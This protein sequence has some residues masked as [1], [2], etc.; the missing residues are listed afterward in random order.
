MPLPF[1]DVARPQ[2]RVLRQLAAALIYEGRID[3]RTSGDAFGTVFTWTATGRR[4]RAFGRIGPFGRPRLAPG[5]VEMNAGGRW[6]TGTVAQLIHDVAAASPAAP[7]FEAELAATI[8]AG[9][10]VGTRLRERR[11]ASFAALESALDEGHPYHPSF[12]SRTGFTAAD[13]ARYGQGAPPFRLIW[14]MVR[15][16]R[17][18]LSGAATRPDFWAEAI[19]PAG[20]E[21]AAVVAERAGWSLEA[22][23]LLPVHPF[24]LA[25]LDGTFAAAISAGAVIPLGATGD[26]YLAGQSLRTLFNV[27]RPAA[28]C[29]K[30]PIDVTNTSIRRVL[31][32]HSVVAAPHLSAWLAG[33]I[34]GDP[35]FRRMPVTL[36][37]EYAG[38]VLDRDDP[39]S[40]RT[41]A[42]WRDS[43]E[44]RLGHGERAVPFTALMAVEDDGRPF[45]DPFIARHGLEPWVERLIEVAVLPVWHL[46]VA[47][48][49]ALEAHGQNMILVLRDG[50]PVRIAL[51]DFHDSV[52]YVEEL[53]PPGHPPPSF[54][55][56]DDAYRDPTPDLF[57]WMRDIEELRWT[58]MDTLFVFNLTE[59]SAL[60]GAAYAYPERAFWERV[61]ERIRR[62]AREEGLEERLARF[63]HETARIKVE[64]LVS[65]KLAPVDPHDPDALPGHAVPNPLHPNTECQGMIEID[66]HRYDRDALTARLAEL[67]GG[68]ALPLRPDRSYA[69]C[70]EDPAVWLAAFFAL[71]EAGASVVPVHPASPPAAARR[72][73]IAA[74]CSHLIYG[75]APPEPLPESAATLAPGQLVQMTSGTT[76]A[77]KPIARTFGEIEDELA[78]YVAAFTAPEGMTPVVAAPTSHSYGLIC[79]LLAGLKRGAMPVVVRPDNPRHLL[80]RLAEVERPVLY[81][82]PAVLHTLARMLSGDERIHAAMTSGTLLP[83][84]WFEAIRGRITNLFQQYGTSESGVIAV[85]PQTERSADMGAVLPHHR[86][87]EDGSRDAPVEIRLATPWR[88]VATRDLGYR[89]DGTLVFLSRLDDT[90]NVAGLNVFPK[91]VEDAVM[92]MPGV[93]DA[94]AFRVADPFAGERVALVYSGDARV[95]EAALRAWCGERLA[96]HQLPAVSAKVPAVPRQ[97]NGKINRREIAAAFAAGDLEHA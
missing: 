13:Q 24:Q 96:G 16:E 90:I 4:W 75:N 82:S 72:I 56:L 61:R 8:D 69:V 74:G 70:H 45:I 62:H 37:E 31:P 22:T 81:T 93:T 54:R 97:A 63:G 12:R 43:V 44:A 58:V 48:G 3:V 94:V 79:G 10:R 87:L 84:P 57:F 2:D 32:P 39:L 38:V 40:D 28:A 95:D 91:E 49:I 46:M 30:L 1:E 86:L 52:E 9:G 34:A 18:S 77:P 14:L 55:A 15:R 42:L 25:Q 83:E 11:D 47:H 21:E 92:A 27:D 23:G 35:A 78:S 5:G 26:R 67:A 20:A 64:S 7:R 71:R 41:S 51:R 53:L 36:L 85:N 68:A 59:V 60:L 80:R 19:G 76:G 17:L 29:I 33:I 50:W 66:G 88:T 89:A 73:A 6:T 65:Q